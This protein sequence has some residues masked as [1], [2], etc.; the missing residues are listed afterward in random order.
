MN[1][2]IEYEKKVSAL[3]VDNVNMNEFLTQI[4]RELS[5]GSEYSHSL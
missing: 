5:K 2:K 1:L 4:K 3:K